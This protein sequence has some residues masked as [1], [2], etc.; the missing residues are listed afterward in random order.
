MKDVNSYA[1]EMSSFLLFKHLQIKLDFSTVTKGVIGSELGFVNFDIR[2]PL[3]LINE[4]NVGTARGCAA[5]FVCPVPINRSNTKRVL[6]RVC[7][8]KM[9]ITAPDVNV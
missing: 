3:A 1:A 4:I 7:R 6:P 2:G 8:K 5:V 9:I